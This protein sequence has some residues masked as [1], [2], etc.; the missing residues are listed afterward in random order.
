[1]CKGFVQKKYR[2]HKP[3]TKEIGNVQMAGGKGVERRRKQKQSSGEEGGETLLWASPCL[4]LTLKTIVTVD[5]HFTDCKLKLY[6]EDT[7]G[8]STLR[9]KPIL[10]MSNLTTLTWGG[11]KESNWENSILTEY[12][13]VK[14]EKNCA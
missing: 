7:K 2:K 4:P 9:N 1:M 10:Q 12:C 8:K 11:E 14:D 13:K 6:K 5:I 3:E